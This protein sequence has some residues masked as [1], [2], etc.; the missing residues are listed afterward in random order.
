MIYVMS[1]RYTTTEADGSTSI[2]RRPDKEVDGRY[3]ENFTCRETLEY[4]RSL[5]GTETVRRTGR[6]I[7]CTSVHPDGTVREVI[8][9]PKAGSL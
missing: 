6:R 7:H 9:T 2:D 3:V 5:G 4:H 8:F 1:D